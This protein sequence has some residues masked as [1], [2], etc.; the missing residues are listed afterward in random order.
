M[1][2]CYQQITELIIEMQAVDINLYEDAFLEKSINKRRIETQCGSIEEYANLLKKNTEESLAFLNSLHISYSEFFRNPLTFS[3][4]ERIVLPTLLQ[5]T[6][7]FQQNELRI[8]SAACAGGQE[9]YTL[10]ILFEELKNGN[11]E[12]FNYRIFA[13]DQNQFQIDEA[14]KGNFPIT[15]L[16]NLT[17]RRLNQW[18][19]K[20]DQTYSVVPHLKEHINFSVFDLFNTQ[21]SSPPA[22]IFGSFDLVICA[23]LLFYYK[24]KYR[25]VILKKVENALSDFG[26]I[27]VGETERDILFEFNF[28]EVFPQSCIFSK[29]WGSKN[30]K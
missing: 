11:A 15:A 19:N 13:T 20:I 14:R 6:I 10:A 12:K 3:V 29:K 1:N 17:I 5:Q 18:F 21:F 16:N 25:E 28:K 4:L 26:F 9:S 22:S 7:G 30:R 8:W 27:I 2:E 23:N 24:P